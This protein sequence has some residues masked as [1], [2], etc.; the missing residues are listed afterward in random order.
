MKEK[1]EKSNGNVAGTISRFLLILLVF[2][3]G[4][5]ILA[6]CRGNDNE[7]TETAVPPTSTSPE[8]AGNAWERVQSTGRLVIGTAADYPPFEYHTE[9]FQ[10]DGMDI[11]LISEIAQKLGVTPEFKDMAFEGLGGAIQLEQVDVAIAAL[12]VTDEREAIVDFSNVYFISEDA[13]LARADDPLDQLQNVEELAAMRV[14]VQRN[15]V[16]DNWLQEN[17]VDTGLMPQENLLEYDKIENAIRDLKENRN[18]IVVLDLQPAEIAVSEG[19]V[20]I[21]GQG[22][23]LQRFAIA[24]AQGEK[25]LQ[26]QINKALTE[27]Q[28]SGRL[29]EIVAEYTDIEPEQIPPLP[30]PAPEKPTPAPTPEGC[31]DGMAF[32]QDL[33]LDDNNMKNPPKM[34]PGVPFQKGW[35]IQNSGTCEWTSGYKLV[36]VSGNTPLARMGGEPTAVQGVVPSGQQY[37]M[38]VDLVSPLYAGVYQGFWQMVND[39]NR[40]FGERIWVGIEVVGPPTAT[41][42]PTQT[43]SA[44]MAF[45]VNATNITAG[46]CVIFNWTVQGAQAVYFYQLGANWPQYQVAP[47]SSSTE[48]PQ[49]TTTYELRAAYSNGTSELRQITIYVTPNTAAPQIT[50]FTVDPPA[51]AA[52]GQTITIAWTVEGEVS[53]V[54]LLRSDYLLWDGAPH[55]GSFQDIPPATGLAQYKLIATGPGGENQAVHNVNIV[56]APSATA[57]PQPDTPVIHAFSVQPVQINVGQCVRIEWATGGGTSTVDIKRNNDV[58]LDNARLSGSAQDCPGDPGAYTY[59]IIAAGNNGQSTTQEV[60][61]NAAP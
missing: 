2:I 1:T 56:N 9:E 3:G 15:T 33:N 25:E 61:V 29:T 57:T 58:I 13:A 31:I 18:D 10:L 30:T 43:P 21:V 48:C 17:L 12:S 24:M 23:N 37:D 54:K 5:L 47:T 53:N 32:V 42:A 49:T 34:P 19:G 35:R 26:E 45:T 27:L 46:Q 51:E 39:E 60:V 40:P 22:L 20:K 8:A 36:Y 4:A 52:K 44:G 16:Y 50:R 11:V 41:P 38:W 55:S 6:A 59:Q 14:A 28:N 7:S